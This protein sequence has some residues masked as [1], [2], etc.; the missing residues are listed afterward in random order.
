MEFNHDYFVDG[1]FITRERHKQT[2]FKN[3]FTRFLAYVFKYIFVF[4][5]LFLN[6]LFKKKTKKYEYTISICG[7]FKNEAKFLDEWIKYHLVIGIDHF[8]LYNNNS[9][10]NFLEILKP[11]IDS[12]VVELIDWPFENSQMKAYE[13]CYKNNKLK[14][15]WLTFIDIDEFI[16]PI[17][18]DCIKS[19]LKSYSKYPGVAV[20]WK[21]FGSNGRLAHDKDKY[22][23]EQYTQCWPK[24]STFTKMFCNMEFEILDF[25][26]MHTL[27]TKVFGYNIPPFNQ[28]K[29]IIYLGIHSSFGLIN[30]NIQINHYW[31]KA[32]DIF[33]EKLNRS[34]AHFSNSIDRRAFRKNLLNSHE[35][36]CSEKDFKIMRFLLPTK[37]KE[38]I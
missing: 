5:L 9:D 7:I 10:D 1:D 21:Q 31:N 25:N 28:F 35:L 15:N 22:V 3:N 16:C 8:Y 4:L 26:N 24:F 36:M 19:W 34:D 37:M 20:Y 32:Q 30:N 23:I 2:I 38:V 17:S 6:R 11:Y 33:D 27:N 29:N 14:T 13:D 12:N 18:S